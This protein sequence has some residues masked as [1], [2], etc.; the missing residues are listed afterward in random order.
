M[1]NFISA[2]GYDGDSAIVDKLRKSK[3][4]GKSISTLLDEGSF[5]AATAYAIYSDSDEDLQ[6]VADRYNE[7]SNSNYK[8]EQMSKLFGV[9]KVAVKKHI[10]L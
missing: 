7:V 10:F 6:L 1:D 5:R 3:N 4:K 2:I 9:S 8:K